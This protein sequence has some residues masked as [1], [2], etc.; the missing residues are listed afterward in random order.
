MKIPIPILSVAVTAAIVTTACSAPPVIHDSG[1]SPSK[2]IGSERK[3]MPAEV[4][5]AAI[6]AAKRYG[7]E[8]LDTVS[9]HAA[10]TDGRPVLVGLPDGDNP[11][12][13][14]ALL[15]PGDEQVWILNSSSISS[16][17]HALSREQL[18]YGCGAGM[19]IP[20][21]R[22]PVPGPV[23]PL[24]QPAAR[25]AMAA[26]VPYIYGLPS[27][28]EPACHTAVMLP[29]EVRWV[30]N[31]SG[32]ATVEGDALDRSFQEYGCSGVEVPGDPATSGGAR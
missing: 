18:Q 21:P 16:A 7:A 3:I 17:G 2:T 1:P 4:A 14:S 32:G 11:T 29:G 27:G 31:R 26:K 25:A 13:H 6:A 24:D 9:A 20:T 23:L 19:E 10:L 30:L 5:S 15:V 22:V 12:C 8:Q 28:P